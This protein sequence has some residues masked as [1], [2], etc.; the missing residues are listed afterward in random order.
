MIRVVLDCG[1]DNTND[2]E[3]DRYG[4]NGEGDNGRGG[5]SSTNGGGHCWWW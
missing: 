4:G 5:S 1:K 3:R 2:G